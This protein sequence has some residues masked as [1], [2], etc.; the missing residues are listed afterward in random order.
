MPG[1]PILG[2]MVVATL[3][4]LAAHAGAP[5]TGRC[6]SADLDAPVVLPDGSRHA[7]GSLEICTS[8]VHSPVASLH[9]TRIDGHPVGVYLG[10]SAPNEE[11][12][13]GREPYMVF[14]RSDRGDL[15]L[16]GFV[17]PDGDRM[18]AFR[19]ELAD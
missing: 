15:V 19:M 18:R 7:A 5:E 16:R 11:R 8:R 10:Q 4:F 2:L 3:S 1:K 12:S 14:G 6:I 13:A 9:D 17:V